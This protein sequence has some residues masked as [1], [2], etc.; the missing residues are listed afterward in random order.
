[1]SADTTLPTTLTA[2][3][4]RPETRLGVPVTCSKPSNQNAVTT[5]TTADLSWLSTGN[6]ELEWGDF[7]FTQ[8]A[9]TTLTGLQNFTSL[10]GLMPS[11]VYDYYV[12]TDCGAGDFSAWSVFHFSFV[13]DTIS[14]SN[15]YYF[16]N[17]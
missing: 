15:Y 7:N 12:R 6:T 11:S 3:A 13:L 16:Q 9:G 10:S 1:M 4:F 17:F 8:G 5:L 2:S 14:L